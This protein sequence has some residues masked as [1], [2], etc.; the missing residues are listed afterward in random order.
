MSSELLLF[1]CLLKAGKPGKGQE[2]VSIL[3]AS[4]SG[5]RKACNRISVIMDAAR[6]KMDFT[7]FVSVPLNA[8]QIMEAFENFKAKVLG[9]SSS[10]S[11]D[12]L[13]DGGK[14]A[15]VTE[16]HFQPASSL[17]LTFAMLTLLGGVR[18]FFL[19]TSRKSGENQ[20]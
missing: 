15:V 7:H 1:F 3:G 9:L 11:P 8:P 5:V 13:S 12:G 6:A 16:S 14:E 18:R 20:K 4:E 10:S 17:H 19:Q 2:P